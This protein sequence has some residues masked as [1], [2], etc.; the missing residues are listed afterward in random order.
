MK[1]VAHPMVVA[2]AL[3][4]VGPSVLEERLT[5][6]ERSAPCE[7]TVSTTALF[8]L[9]AEPSHEEFARVEAAWSEIPR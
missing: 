6:A 8:D 9:E 2:V 5:D 7:D 4:L 1:I 3:G